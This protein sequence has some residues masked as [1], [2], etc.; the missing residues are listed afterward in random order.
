MNLRWPPKPRRR[1][2]LL[3]LALACPSAVGLVATGHAAPTLA[4]QRQPG[5]TF[6]PNANAL[7]FEANHGQ[8]ADEV[9]YAARG[10]GYGL[11]LS[12]AGATL[13]LQREGSEQP[14]LVAMHVAG[15][16]PVE[17]V[18]IQQLAGVTNY[19]TGVAG[20][21]RLDG[22][23]SFSAAKYTDILPGVDL[24]YYATSAREL[25]YDFLLAP[26]V[27]PQTLEVGFD[28]VEA[29]A[30]SASGDASLQLV[31]GGVLQQRRPVA[32]QLDA[33]GA[34]HFVPA[35]FRALGGSRLGF[36]VT[37]FDRRR[38]LVIDP[39][40]TYATY[41]GGSKFDE[42]AA[43]AV[44]S[45]GNTVSV[46]YTTG[47]LFPTKVP[48][49]PAYGGG[50]S[51][52]VIVKLNAAGT[53][54]VYSTYLGGSDTDR[55]YGV[56]VDTIGSAYVTGITY[57]TN[58]PT[59]GAFQSSSG[60]GLSDGF[61]AK[62]NAAGG[63]VY[64]TYLGGSGD[65]WAQAIAVNA[66]GEAYVTGTTYSQNFPRLG[67]FQNARAGDNDAFVS[68]LSAAGGSL[69]FSTYLGGSGAGGEYGQ[70]IALDPTG[71]AIVV[72]ETGSSNFPTLAPAQANIAGTGT[73]SD[74]F[75][76]RFNPAGSS[77][78]YSTY[79]GGSS[80]D[81]ALGVAQVGGAALVVGYTASS[82]FPH[83]GGSQSTL[84]GDY[85]GFFTR[86]H[87]TGGAFDY[88]T[89]IGGSGADQANAIAI[90]SNGFVY[91]AGK[92][93]SSNFPK[94]L[95]LPGQEALNGASDAFLAGFSGGEKAFATFLGG[96]AADG[97]V[98]IAS[99][100]GNTL[101]VVGNT[102][103][104][105]FPTVSPLFPSPLG[106]QDGFVARLTGLALSPAPAGSSIYWLCLAGLLLGSGL[107]AQSHRRR[108]A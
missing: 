108:P 68:K 11:S 67:A 106:P 12:R 39:V 101:H 103:S 10:K 75:V 23:P 70:G 81:V 56:A 63:L 26:G 53:D 96:S 13:A 97:A 59:Q 82:D 52:V 46:G 15:A 77:L 20:Q 37:G 45:T 14:A 6:R 36:E 85:D 72:G 1:L 34:R 100:P 33:T 42:F 84:G 86:V 43:V 76:T 8:F 7:R 47:N 18:G 91:V 44:D 107:V 66:A 64:S 83:L 31:G 57:S 35:A 79:L 29:L 9:R 4:D 30:V 94:Q 41:L 21:Q 19:A 61:I 74:A 87:G 105:D 65:D 99:A 88:S 27:D 16:A 93:A 49:Q 90:D 71:G 51:D 5:P 95:P 22:V 98:G 69:V 40:L 24:L 73:L 54:F 50:N 104:T 17:P 25:E 58:F 48:A 78:V 92:T 2:R 60:G 89:F 32:Y 80:V 28:G 102:F 3:G 55:G 62:L 38:A